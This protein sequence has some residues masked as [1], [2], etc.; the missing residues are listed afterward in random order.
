M[1]GD[2]RAGLGNHSIF[3]YTAFRGGRPGREKNRLNVPKK[4]RSL[5]RQSSS[6]KDGN[7]KVGAEEKKTTRWPLGEEKSRIEG[8]KRV[9][10]SLKVRSGAGFA[11]EAAGSRRLLQGGECSQKGRKKGPKDKKE[12]RPDQVTGFRPRNKKKEFPREQKKSG[13]ALWEPDRRGVKNAPTGGERGVVFEKKKKPDK[14]R[15]SPGLRLH[16]K[17]T[18]RIGRDDPRQ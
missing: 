17:K 3:H 1:R 16:R 8:G 6:E 11:E 10:S 2:G 9:R 15:G 7:R 4:G 12:V 13:L 14:T 18:E 5:C